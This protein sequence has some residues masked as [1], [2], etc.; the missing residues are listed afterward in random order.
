MKNAVVFVLI[1]LFAWLAGTAMNQKYQAQ[2]AE[3]KRAEMDYRLIGRWQFITDS[4]NLKRLGADA[5]LVRRVSTAVR[6][7]M[8]PFALAADGVTDKAVRR[9]IT[10]AGDCLGLVLD[11]ATADE[12]GSMPVR[13]EMRITRERVGAV[14]AAV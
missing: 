1:C 11:L 13:D 9:F 3:E 8:R 2:A 4:S 10:E 6:L 7:H 14:L 5:E 12:L